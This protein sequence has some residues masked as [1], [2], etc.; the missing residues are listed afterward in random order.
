MGRAGWRSRAEAPQYSATSRPS[1]D[2]AAT[3]VA[4]NAEPRR[5]RVLGT[6]EQL[7]RLPTFGDGV[8]HS[9]PPLPPL[10]CR[11]CIMLDAQSCCPTRGVH[12]DIRQMHT[13]RTDDDDADAVR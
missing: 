11:A 4:R 8:G 12:P 6:Q 3:L 2:W 5:M 13:S 7:A 9:L 10:Q 1:K